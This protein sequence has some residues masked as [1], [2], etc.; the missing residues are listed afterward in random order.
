MFRFPLKILTASAMLLAVALP[1]SPGIASAND[2][3]LGNGN[4]SLNVTAPTPNLVVIDSSLPIQVLSRGYRLDA[5]YAG[6]TVTQW[7]GHYHEILDGNLVDMTPTVDPNNDTM[8]MAGVTPGSHT[9]TIVPACND[10]SM[11]MSA[12]VNVPFTYAGPQLPLPAPV[13]FPDAPAITITSPANGAFVQGGSFD[14]TV[15]VSNFELCEECYGKANITGVGHWHV[16]ADGP[17]MANMKAM[18]GSETQTVTLQ[19]VTPG[20]HTFYAVLVDNHHMPFM[21]MPSTM[22]MVTVN[23]FSRA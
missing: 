17:V 3:S 13:T 14:M 23:V 16:F 9:L 12:A 22:A 10:H 19:G 18:A 21:D 4:V 7:D 1:A 2:C 15:A 8:S 11:V 20:P 6:T 5:R